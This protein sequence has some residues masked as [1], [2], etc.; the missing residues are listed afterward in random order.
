MIGSL[1]EPGTATLNLGDILAKDYADS[2]LLT[3]TIP[4]QPQQPQQPQHVPNARTRGDAA[5]ATATAAKTA[6]ATITDATIKSTLA[7]ATERVDDSVIVERKWDGDRLLAH[8]GITDG[9]K[10]PEVWLFTRHGTPVHNMYKDITASLQN[11]FSGVPCG[12][13]VLDGEL[14]VVDTSDNKPMPWCNGKW[15]FDGGGGMSVE[16]AKK[17]S[18]VLASIVMD[19]TE[20]EAE[21]PCRSLSLASNKIG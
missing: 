15:R 4:L 18:V 13:Y 17:K 10:P 12:G 11:A 1:P 21:V 16:E 20:A 3:V 5:A 7:L 2:E 14:I 8:I 6:A 19:R 9:K